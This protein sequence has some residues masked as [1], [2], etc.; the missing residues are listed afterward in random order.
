M[1][2][3]A[4][5]HRALPADDLAALVERFAEDVRSGCY[6]IRSDSSQR[7]HVR[8]HQDELV[9]VWLISW[10]ESQRTELHDHGDS[11]GVFTVVKGTLT[12]AVWDGSALR[13]HTLE[14]G[15]TVRFES[16]YVHDVYNQAGEVA[17]SVHAYSPPLSRMSY[18]DVQDGDL[19]ALATT[20]T[21]DP[22]T[23][24]PTYASVDELL[25]SARAGL[26]RL[27]PVEAA[28]AIEEGALLVD[29]RPEWQR[30]RDGEV[31]G[32]LIV[33]RNHLEWRLHPASDARIKQAVAGQRWV[34]ICAEGYTSS[35]AAASLNSLGLPAA[36]VIGGIAAW[37]DAG[38]PVVAGAT[39]V[40]HVVQ[41]SA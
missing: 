35:L 19:M 29:I 25:A 28:A 22:E 15:E 6:E 33:E 40:E 21:D 20:W 18:Y 24:A 31:P 39:A 8:I 17:V 13:E 41:R 11:R 30:R 1:T 14:S 12:E 3:H 16:A 26:P 38:L 4:L 27:A 23:P 7:W 37:A 36:D 2:A 32:S 9:D 5:A 10:T 34:V